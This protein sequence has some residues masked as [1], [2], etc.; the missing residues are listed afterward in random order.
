VVIE[1]DVRIGA[2]T[3]LHGFLLRQ[4]LHEPRRAQRHPPRRRP[5]RPAAI[6]SF[7]GGASYV[8][9]ARETSAARDHP[10]LDARGKERSSATTT[11]SFA[12]HAGHDCVIGDRNI[13]TN[14]P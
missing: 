12:L 7:K 14:A 13:I 11:T 4:A 5:R 6:L 8:R 9:S 1:N 3:E 2:G 10:P